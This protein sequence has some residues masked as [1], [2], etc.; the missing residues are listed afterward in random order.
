MRFTDEFVRNVSLRNEWLGFIL[1]CFEFPF[2]FSAMTG[3]K[4]STG[5]RLL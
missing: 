1:V 5:F 4:G 3:F 2:S